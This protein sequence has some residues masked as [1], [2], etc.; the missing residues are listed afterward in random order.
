M[1]QH[2]LPSTCR[3]ASE[4]DTLL[5]RRLD[6]RRKG[7]ASKAAMPFQQLRTGTGWFRRRALRERPDAKNGYDK[8]AAGRPLMSRRAKVSQNLV[9][10]RKSSEQTAEYSPLR[11][12]SRFNPP[13]TCH[14]FTD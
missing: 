1:R 12:F 3:S 2:S 4:S 8:L 5:K 11:V 6:G 14:L 7:T 10:S 9:L 13:S